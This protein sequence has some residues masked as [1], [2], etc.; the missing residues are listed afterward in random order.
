M[1]NKKIAAMGLSVLL[2]MTVLTVPAFAHGHHSGG[3]H[4]QAERSCVVSSSVGAD[5]SQTAVIGCP[6]HAGSAADCPVCVVDGCTET[7]H[8]YHDDTVY[9]GY[10]HAHGYCDGTCAQASDT[11]PS[12]T[13]P[14]NGNCLRHH[15]CY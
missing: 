11:V 6:V 9:C 7:G 1:F 3:H 13:S 15:S 12:R 8:H 14:D 2:S 10:P 5:T 4:R